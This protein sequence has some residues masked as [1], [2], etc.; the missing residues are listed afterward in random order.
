[1]TDAPLYIY[2]QKDT[3][4]EE[5]VEIRTQD[6]YDFVGSAFGPDVI[7]PSAEDRRYYG[8]VKKDMPPVLR[9][10]HQ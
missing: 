4:P 9:S 10:W 5:R 7:S 8:S 1:M 2:L 3:D 6:V